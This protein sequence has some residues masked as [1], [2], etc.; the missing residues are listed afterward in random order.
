MPPSV[1]SGRLAGLL[2]HARTAFDR[3]VIVLVCVHALNGTDV[4]RLLLADLD[5]P[6]E[7]ILVRR[8]S[9]RHTVYLDD[10]SYRFASEWTRERHRRWPVPGRRLAQTVSS[11]RPSRQRRP[12][13]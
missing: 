3:F 9:L 2:G 6:R 13:V 12:C 5:L 11:M 4:R 10:V 7:R 8:P 1:P